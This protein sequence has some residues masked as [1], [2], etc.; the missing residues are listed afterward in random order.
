MLDFETKLRCLI[1]VELLLSNKHTDRLFFP[2][3]TTHAVISLI[4]FRAHKSK[5]SE[6]KMLK[7]SN[8]T[9]VIKP[10]FTDRGGL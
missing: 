10:K 2:S 9:K 4:K 8:N 6:K 1:K 7:Y 5:C 3:N